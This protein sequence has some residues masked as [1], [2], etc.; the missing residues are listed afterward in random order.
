[1]R[2]RR[3][4]GWKAIAIVEYTLLFPLIPLWLVIDAYE[5]G[6]AKKLI[7][8]MDHGYV[9]NSPV[10]AGRGISPPPPPRAPGALWGKPNTELGRPGLDAV[11]PLAALTGDLLKGNKHRQIRRR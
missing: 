4:K 6:R 3:T 9:P 1:M 5:R 10:P 11:A 2:V 7:V 8:K